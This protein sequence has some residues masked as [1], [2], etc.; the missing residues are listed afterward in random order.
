MP[1]FYHFGPHSILFEGPL[2]P[3]GPPSPHGEVRIVMDRQF[4]EQALP[5]F[6]G[7]E[8]TPKL[9]VPDSPDQESD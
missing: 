1:A 2:D 7:M 8:W 3:E 9:R 4:I 5:H 6:L